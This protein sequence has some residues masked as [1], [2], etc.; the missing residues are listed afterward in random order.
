MTVEDSIQRN[1][2]K[3]QRIGTYGSRLDGSES[4][5]EVWDAAL[6]LGDAPGSVD[7]D[8]DSAE[9]SR[10]SCFI[11]LPGSMLQ[12]GPPADFST[13]TPSALHAFQRLLRHPHPP[14]FSREHLLEIH[15]YTLI[16]PICVAY[17]MIFDSVDH[18]LQVETGEEI[19]ELELVDGLEL[20]FDAGEGAGCARICRS[21]SARCSS[22]C[23]RL[24]L[25]FNA[26]L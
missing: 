8:G 12:H 21:F 13:A 15:I 2:N 9:S 1:K 26:L 14:M 19:Y 11:C 24:S 5:K 20:G 10:C 18:G 25:I 6:G 17:T 16:I 4:G 23:M 3:P 7:D 22:S